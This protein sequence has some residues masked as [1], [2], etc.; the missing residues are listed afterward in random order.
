MQSID[1]FENNMPSPQRAVI[2]PK[3]SCLE[4]SKIL[5]DSDLYLRDGEVIKIDLRLPSQKLFQDNMLSLLRLL[6]YHPFSGV[7]KMQE[8]TKNDISIK[9]LPQ[10]IKSGTINRTSQFDFLVN[11]IFEKCEQRLA[12]LHE[13]IKKAID[14]EK[15]KFIKESQEPLYQGLKMIKS[16]QE[17][18]DIVK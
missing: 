7:L 15:T 14:E 9:D 11:S 3:R 4:D 18:I 5:R 2:T 1:E 8:I 12:Y 16:P 6:N 17:R 10:A 13:S